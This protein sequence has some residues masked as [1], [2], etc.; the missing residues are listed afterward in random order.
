MEKG[1]KR[2]RGRREILKERKG[3]ER[4]GE[5]GRKKMHTQRWSEDGERDREK[6]GGGERMREK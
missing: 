3:G 1:R 5:R 6:R 4:D 2:R